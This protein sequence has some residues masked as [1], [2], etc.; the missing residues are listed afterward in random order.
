[1]ERFQ[2]R[3]IT[4][5]S[6]KSVPEMSLQPLEALIMVMIRLQI[7]QYSVSL[8]LFHLTDGLVQSLTMLSERIS[9]VTLP[10]AGVSFQFDACQ[11][12]SISTL[13]VHGFPISLQG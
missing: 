8:N 10:P 13:I 5:S 9:M 7:I 11:S 2:K 3:N 4:Q 6:L 1:M 12:L